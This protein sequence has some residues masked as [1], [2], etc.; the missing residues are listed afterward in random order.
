RG[1]PDAR[2]QFFPHRESYNPSTVD[3]DGTRTILEEAA[4][5]WVEGKGGLIPTAGRSMRPTFEDA[6]R[7]WVEPLERARFGDVVVYSSG[8]FLV[9]HR[10]VGWP[11]G[12]ACRTKG[13]GLP[14]LDRDLV[15][16][17]RILGRVVGV[18]REGERFET[19][20]PGGRVYGLMVG[21]LSAL[22]GLLYR[23]AWRFDRL[24]TPAWHPDASRGGRTTN[25]RALTWMGRVALRSL[26]R[27]FF[28][29]LHPRVARGRP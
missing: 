7:V 22:E 12:R 1:C 3:P 18:E 13:D 11:W 28:R 29:L 26:D 10:V 5:L 15:P 19:D 14:H 23:F 17:E 25:R 20:G 16:R 4:R 27:L 6:S 24:L 21:V 2:G 8:A 9:V